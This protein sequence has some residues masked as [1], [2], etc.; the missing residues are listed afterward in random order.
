MSNI[1]KIC[2]EGGVTSSIRHRTAFTLAEVLVTLAVIG[3]VASLT[4]VPLVKSSSNIQNTVA[5]KKQYSNISRARLSLLADGINLETLFSNSSGFGT[6]AL[7]AFATKMKM[8]KICG[9]G[10][11][12]WYTSPLKYL[13][14]Q[15]YAPNASDRFMSS[16]GGSAILNDGSIIWVYSFRTNCTSYSVDGKNNTCGL[17]KIDVNGAKGPNKWGRD[18]FQFYITTTRIYPHG[19]NYSSYDCDPTD[20]RTSGASKGRGFLCGAYILQNGMDY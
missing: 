9:W 1:F 5:F 12:C 19:T 8:F 14:G 15:I 6:I 11:G 13:N 18:F 16:A 17:I 20:T 4:I 7:N 10:T 3:V 2:R